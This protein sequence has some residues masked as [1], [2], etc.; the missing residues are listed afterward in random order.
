MIC[1]HCSQAFHDEPRR[2]GLL[3]ERV[4][5]PKRFAVD[6]RV[7]P[8]CQRM[9]VGLQYEQ[10]AGGFPIP[11]ELTVWPTSTSRPLPEEIDDDNVRQDYL[12]AAAVLDV[13]PKASAALSRRLLQHIIRERAGI[14]RGT[15][16]DEIDAL[17][18]TGEL[19]AG[20]A[21]DLH[22]VR[23][24]GN[25]AAHP[26]KDRESGVIVEVEPEEAEWLLELLD[27]ML[28]HFYVKPRIRAGR[29]ERFNTK[30]KAAGKAL[31]PGSAESAEQQ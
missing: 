27:D 13:S 5:G 17:V 26:V 3:A 24:V 7:C 4:N 2:H 11:H 19:S 29:R 21:D 15:L 31:L 25:F 22:A 16:S 8:V 1:P 9:I 12:E 28:D 30:L 6:W 14:K 18:A 10:F 23:Q 20:L